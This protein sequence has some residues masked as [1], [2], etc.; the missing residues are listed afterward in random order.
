MTDSETRMMGFYNPMDKEGLPGEDVFAKLSSGSEAS[1]TDVSDL[2]QAFG[3][4]RGLLMQSRGQ[5]ANLQ[6]AVEN[7]RNTLLRVPTHIWESYLLQHGWRRLEGGSPRW[8]IKTLVRDMELLLPRE[9]LK[10]TKLSEAWEDV[11]TLLSRAEGRH[12][13][14]ILAE[15]LDLVDLSYNGSSP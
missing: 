4:L 13:T 7:S 14:L 6:E 12:R 8:G 5:L 15:V 9:G 3:T 1:P 10:G 2:V 11:L